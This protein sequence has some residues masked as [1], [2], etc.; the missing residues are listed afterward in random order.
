MR[1]LSSCRLYETLVEALVGVRA[2]L[3]HFLVLLRCK[4][5]KEVVDRID[6]TT[7]FHYLIMQMRC[8]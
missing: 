5:V 2:D 8:C 6:L 4:V 7:V 3:Q 1:K